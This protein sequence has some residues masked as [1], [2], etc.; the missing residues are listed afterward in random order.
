MKTCISC[1]TEK[2]LSEF[3]KQATSADGYRSRGKECRKEESRKYAK[4]NSLKIV[5]RVKKWVADNPERSKEGMKKRSKAWR[6]KNKDRMR[7][8]WRASYAKNRDK[9]VAEARSYR[10]ANRNKVRESVRIYIK[11]NR[12]I[13]NA[14][15]ANRRALKRMACVRWADMEQIKNE[16]DRCQAHTPKGGK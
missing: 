8:L 10:E 9:R 2:E 11:N 13:K 3:H 16:Y 6:E 12:H 7:E 14:I 4:E 15:D 5:A 1:G